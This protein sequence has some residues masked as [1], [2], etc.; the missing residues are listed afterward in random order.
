M[1]ILESKDERCSKRARNT[2]YPQKCGVKILE[3]FK[4]NLYASFMDGLH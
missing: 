4:T 2:R 1:D 3:C